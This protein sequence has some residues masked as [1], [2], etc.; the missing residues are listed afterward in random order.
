[1]RWRAGVGT[2]VWL[3]IGWHR[4]L[5]MHRAAEG[6]ARGG[7]LRWGLGR[8]AVRVG[9]I[10]RD[11][12]EGGGG[13]GGEGASADAP[14]AAPSDACSA[15]RAERAG[16]ASGGA[17]VIRDKYVSDVHRAP[18]HGLCVGT[19]TPACRRER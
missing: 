9:V 16:A 17:C 11:N 10:I 6:W 4:D 5:G 3:A 2:Y 15:R 13:G 7:V 18:A 8:R 12:N 19:L 1:M 14:A